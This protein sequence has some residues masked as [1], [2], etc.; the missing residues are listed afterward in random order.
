M[1]NL[2]S[3]KFF[4]EALN[5][6]DT[7]IRQYIHKGILAKEFNGLMDIN[8]PLNYKFIVR[9]NGGNLDVFK[10]TD[11][12]IGKKCENKS[13][14]E[15]IELEKKKAD[16]LLVQR[17]AELKLYELEKKAGNSLPLDV[18]ATIQTIMFQTVLSE[19]LLET[20][21]MVQM[22][23]QEFGGNRA[24]TV[25]ITNK[26]RASFDKTLDI[27]KKKCKTKFEIAVNEYSEVRSRGER[28][29]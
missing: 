7:T 24:D 20:E 12:N 3:A 21:K 25:K 23:V 1:D 11:T 22:T 9:K 18:V 2:V 27:V 13:E 14:F 15:D 10:R 4:A 6:K 8:N 17:N 29:V 19:F 28:K 26:L 5:Q 16:L